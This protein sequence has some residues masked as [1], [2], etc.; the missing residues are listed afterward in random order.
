MVT[1]SRQCELTLQAMLMVKYLHW[2]GWEGVLCLDASLQGLGMKHDCP[3]V[4][5]TDGDKHLLLNREFLEIEG[6]YC[7]GGFQRM[8][9]DLY[10]LSDE[11]L[12][13]I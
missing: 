11:P 7:D 1:D 5:D 2:S 3:E 6:V 8:F 10:N 9:E 4:F 12:M 13:P